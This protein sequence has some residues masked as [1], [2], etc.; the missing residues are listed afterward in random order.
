MSPMTKFLIGVAIQVLVFLGGII[1]V[2]RH[3]LYQR[4]YEVIRKACHKIVHPAEVDPAL[5]KKLVILSGKIE[6]IH[7]ELITDTSF[8]SVCS[9]DCLAIKRSIEK[10][11]IKEKTETDSEGRETVK[12][13][14]TWEK[15]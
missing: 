2:I 3:H 9:T 14:R 11:V 1:L 6:K 7:D 15:Y 12:Y 13:E 8:N 10:Y 4:H 5:D